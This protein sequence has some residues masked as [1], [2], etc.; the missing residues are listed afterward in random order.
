MKQFLIA[1]V[2]GI[3]AFFVY[4]YQMPKPVPVSSGSVPGEVQSVPSQDLSATT[5]VA[6]PQASV[7]NSTPE[8]VIPHIRKTTAQ[9]KELPP[10]YDAQPESTI[11]I[12]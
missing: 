12:Q 1:L 2:I 8:A 4:Q 9:P 3:V 7:E 5:I 10:T 6:S 11:L